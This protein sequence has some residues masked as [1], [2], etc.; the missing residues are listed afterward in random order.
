[1]NILR[2]YG[3]PRLLMP[4]SLALPPVDH[5]R[6]TSPSQAANSRPFL[7]AAPFPIADM[8]AVDTNGPTPGICC[9]RTQLGSLFAICSSSVLR[10]SICSCRPFHSCHKKSTR[11]RMAG[12]NL[13]SAFSRISGICRTQARRPLAET[14]APLQ[15]E[16]S[17]L[18]DHAGPSRHQPVAHSMESLQI[19]LI[20][21][22]DGNETHVLPFHGFGDGLRIAVVVFVG[23]HERSHKLRWNHPHLVPLL[24]Q[25]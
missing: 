22:L 21:C 5:C 24:A 23:L 4:R 14:D 18:I 8:T 20:F 6:G 3:F 12:L 15:Q 13:T 9:N 17:N 10:L 11:R 25:R 19:E 16:G 1:M 2:R 7:N